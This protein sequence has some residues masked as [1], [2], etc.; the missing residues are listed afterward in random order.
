MK[1]QQMEIVD[2]EV[3]GDPRPAPEGKQV[4]GNGIEISC[5]YKLY[6]PKSVKKKFELRLNDSQN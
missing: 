5:K 2:R 3:T 6:E 4:I 1:N